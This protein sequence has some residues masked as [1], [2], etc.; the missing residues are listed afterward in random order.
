[1]IFYLKNKSL[2]PVIKKML[3]NKYPKTL[4]SYYT[5]KVSPATMLNICNPLNGKKKKKYRG[6]A[7]QYLDN[8]QAQCI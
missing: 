1:M 6:I 4:E 3:V 5:Y 2:S 7:H 8:Y